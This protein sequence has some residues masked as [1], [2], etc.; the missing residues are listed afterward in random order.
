M[1]VS[2]RQKLTAILATSLWLGALV[3]P[4]PAVAEEPYH[5]GVVL[6]LTGTGAPYSK[7]A[8]EGIEIAVNEI[9]G[10]GGLLGK[11]PIKLFIRNTQTRPEVAEAVV[12][13][14]IQK[15][16]V[17]AVIGTYSSATSLAIKP[18]C[19]EYKVLQIA[20]ISNSE[21]ITKL[22]PSPY[23][24]SVVPNTYMMSNAVVIGG[25]KLA[26]ANGWTKYATIASDY[27]WGRSSQQVQVEL[28]KRVAPNIELVA[29][30]WPRLGQTRF[31]SFVVAAMAEKPDFVLTSIAG[32]DNALWRRDAREYRFFMKIANPGGLISVTELMRNAKTIRR[33]LYG[34]T[35]APFF[36]HLDVPMMADFVNNYLSNFY[37]YPTDWAVMSY[38][39][40]YALKQGIEKAG[41]VETEKVKDAMKGLTINT[42]RGRLFFREIDNQLSASAYFGRVADDPD[43]AFPIYADLVEFKGP[44]IWRPE[45][46]ILAARRK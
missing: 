8:V 13:E 38:D 2:N 3:A 17:R 15:D 12:T 25:A 27:A 18:I 39:G 28:L 7:E 31:N 36:A 24:F 46:E 32:A 14:L 42:T 10:Q 21:D 30:F 6:G 9:N 26:V 4:G 37:R 19:R 20:T 5:L 23:T 43:Y 11:H 33:G 16:K 34:R 44:E 45:K 22:N 40:V 1:W 35:R 41:S 29:E